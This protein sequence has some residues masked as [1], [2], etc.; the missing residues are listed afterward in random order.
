V[1]EPRALVAPSPL[2]LREAAWVAFL[3]TAAIAFSQPRV[4]I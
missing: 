2:L 3:V 1:A 4:K